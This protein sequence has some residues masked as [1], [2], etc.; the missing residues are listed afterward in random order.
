M[1]YSTAQL[2][3][4]AFHNIKR[5]RIKEMVEFLCSRKHS[6]CNLYFPEG[7]DASE[8]YPVMVFIG[9]SSCTGNDAT[10][11]LTQGRDGPGWAVK[12][13]QSVYPTIVALPTY[14]ETIPDDHVSCRTTDM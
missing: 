9:D 5:S 12:A 3:R 14:P 10:V 7:Y 4:M 6:H 11:S 8:S 13:W 1:Q 2:L